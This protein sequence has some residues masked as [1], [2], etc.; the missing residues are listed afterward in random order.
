MRRRD[1]SGEISVQI[2]EGVTAYRPPDGTIDESVVR[3][4]RRRQDKPDPIVRMDPQDGTEVHIVGVLRERRIDVDVYQSLGLRPTSMSAGFL[5]VLGTGNWSRITLH[6]QSHE[7][8]LLSYTAWVPTEMLLFD[9]QTS[10]TLQAT[11]TQQTLPAG[12]EWICESLEPM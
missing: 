8:Q 3:A 6:C 5:G 2:S 11:L 7:D 10:M 12:S 9:F 4:A 1:A